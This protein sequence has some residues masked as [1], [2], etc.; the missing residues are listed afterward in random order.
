MRMMV[1]RQ[2]RLAFGSPLRLTQDFYQMY[3]VISDALDANRA[4]LELAHRDFERHEKRTKRNFE[5]IA[6]DTVLRMVV[7]KFVENL[8]FRDTVIRIDDS[9]MLR[10][11]CRIYDDPPID[12]TTFA[13]LT[14]CIQPQ[15]WEEI[16]KLLVQFCRRTKGIAGE[17][18]RLDTTAVETDIHF[19]TDASLLMDSN[20]VLTRILLELR[21]L[22]HHY[23]GGFRS[24]VKHAKRLAVAIQRES[25]GNRKRKLYRKLLETTGRVVQYAQAAREK[26][27]QIPANAARALRLEMLRLREALKRYV[28]LAMRCVDQARRRVLEGETV[29]NGEKLFSIFE[30]HT[31]LLIRGKADKPIEFGHMLELHQVERGLITYYAVHAQRPVEPALLGAAVAAHKELF[32]RLPNA[33]AA[34]KGFFDAAEVAKLQAIGIRTVGICKRGKRT[35]EEEQHEHGAL[36]RAAQRFRAGIE[37]AISALKRA[38]GLRRCRNKGWQRFRSWVGAAIFARN[39]VWLAGP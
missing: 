21:D 25:K 31:E 26:V 10:F 23:T 39:L 19:P 38:F 33:A 5:G 8:S 17:K 18:L 6:S 24:R 14:H 16:N 3:Q 29:P 34:D 27:A 36:F 32:G 13:K 20:R 11:F 15:T 9:Q 12:F 7:V 35:P 1:D 2:L 37:G 30:P 22:G 28:P 4:I